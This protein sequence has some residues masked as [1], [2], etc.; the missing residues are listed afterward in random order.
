M[1]YL[2]S[3]RKDFSFWMTVDD[4]IKSCLNMFH[5]EYPFSL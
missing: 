5:A 4:K 2:L 3:L 1:E